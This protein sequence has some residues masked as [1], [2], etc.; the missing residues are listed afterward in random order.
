MQGPLVIIVGGGFLFLKMRK[1]MSGDKKGGRDSGGGR[2]GPFTSLFN[3]GKRGGRS[4]ERLRKL[5]KQ[6]ASPDGREAAMKSMLSSSS[7]VDDSY[8]DEE[9]VGGVLQLLY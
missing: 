6:L 5:T 9:G 3:R 8:V 1:S 2:G 7:S 4:D